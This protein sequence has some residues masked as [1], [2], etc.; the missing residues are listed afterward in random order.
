MKQVM[1]RPDPDREFPGKYV[2]S[3]PVPADVYIGGE[4]VEAPYTGVAI[5]K[6]MFPS[7]RREAVAVAIGDYFKESGVKK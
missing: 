7:G 4:K 3:E 5:G 6:P 2:F 1:M